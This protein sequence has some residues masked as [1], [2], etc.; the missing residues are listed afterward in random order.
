MIEI[1]VDQAALSALMREVKGA[2]ERARDTAAM[3][4]D[5]GWWLRRRIRR[6][7]AESGPGWAPVRSW[8]RAGRQTGKPLLLTKKLRDSIQYTSG[9]SDA[10][11]FSEHP[12]AH[13]H[14]DG[15]TITGKPYLAIPESPPLR[16]TQADYYRTRKI[17][18]GFVLPRD[19]LKRKPQAPGESRDERTSESGDG[20][21]G[22]GVY[23]RE[24]GRGLVR[25][26]AFVRS[27]SVP[28][29]RFMDM[30]ANDEATIARRWRSFILTGRFE[31]SARKPSSSSGA[32]GDDA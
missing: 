1:S 13:L 18:G 2:S 5:A 21:I 6:R 14:N 23:K 30:D 26:K 15:G 32:V 24:R 22:P 12:A 10:L 4:A 19:F 8:P 17:E 25:Y 11:V 7:F 3:C 29:R 27:V 28:P 16:G 20:Y 31:G 9:A